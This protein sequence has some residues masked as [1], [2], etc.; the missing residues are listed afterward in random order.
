MSAGFERYPYSGRRRTGFTRGGTIALGTL[1]ALAGAGMAIDNLRD[2]EIAQAVIIVNVM[3]VFSL[4]TFG[5]YPQSQPR[6]RFRM[7]NAVVMT[8]A[9]RPPIDSWV[10]LAPTRA[11]RTTLTIGFTWG[12]LGVL[13]IA[14][15]GVLQLT[16]VL[17]AIGGRTELGKAIFAVALATLIGGVGLWLS[18]LLI[19]RR[20]RNGSFGTRPSGVALGEVAV[21]VRVPGADV[22]IPWTRIISVTPEVAQAGN[23]AH[24]IPMMRLKLAPGGVPQEVQMLSGEGYKVPIDALYTALRWYQAHPETR[25]ELGRVEGER[26]LEGWRVDALARV[27]QE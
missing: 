6:G 14:V 4:L 5:V 1:L 7:L 9:E 16:G 18:S 20:I 10:H 11:L 3:G 26:R 12:S 19:W 8:R 17:P 25:W 21:A 2:G 15:I 24:S 23:R 22:E 13:A 27:P